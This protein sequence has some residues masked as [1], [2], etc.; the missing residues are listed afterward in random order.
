MDEVDSE[1]LNMQRARM[2][3]YQKF[4]FFFSDGYLIY[5]GRKWA[6]MGKAEH[7]MVESE[8][9]F[10]FPKPLPRGRL[11]SLLCKREAWNAYRIHFR[12]DLNYTWGDVSTQC[13]R[14]HL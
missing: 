7:I 10:F 14:Q 13:F 6:N 2:P 9:I 11:E 5:G 3:G 12:Y 1:K 4:Y 8:R